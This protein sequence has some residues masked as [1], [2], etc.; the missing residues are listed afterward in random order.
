MKK[1]IEVNIESTEYVLHSV[2][3]DDYLIGWVVDMG[4]TGFIVFD[5]EYNVISHFAESWDEAI[6]RLVGKSYG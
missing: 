1:T 4:D 2:M 6:A 3:W 5:D